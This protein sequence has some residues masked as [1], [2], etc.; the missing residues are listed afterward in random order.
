MVGLEAQSRDRGGGNGNERSDRRG[1]MEKDKRPERS[2]D[3]RSPRDIKNALERTPD[4][5]L[6]DEVFRRGLILRPILF[7]PT[8]PILLSEVIP[9]DLCTRA[10]QDPASGAT[11][12]KTYFRT[13]A[14]SMNS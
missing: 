10:R 2:E 14:L 4:K 5:D 11:A 12:S 6:L 8:D 1:L 13:R 7:H 9:P 3:T